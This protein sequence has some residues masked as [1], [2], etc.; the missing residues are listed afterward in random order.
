M[1]SRR[2]PAHVKRPSS[3]ASHRTVRRHARIDEM[4]SLVRSRHCPLRC[5]RLCATRRR[6]HCRLRTMVAATLSWG[7]QAMNHNRLQLPA[8]QRHTGI[9]C[10]RHLGFPSELALNLWPVPP[11]I[12]TLS[13]SPGRQDSTAALGAKGRGRVRNDA[14]VTYCLDCIT[15]LPKQHLFHLLVLL[16]RHYPFGSPRK[17]GNK[18]VL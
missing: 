1:P 18:P 17:T 7:L 3:V 14:S 13:S 16:G 2:R 5:H 15:C 4:C 6:A 12:T 9:A 11:P 10:G 8:Q